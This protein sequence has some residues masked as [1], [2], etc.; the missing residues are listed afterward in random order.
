MSLPIGFV[1][2]PSGK[3]AAFR[4][5]DA[6]SVAQCHG[7]WTC[8]RCAPGKYAAIEAKH[9]A[10]V[11]VRRSLHVV[12]TCDCGSVQIP[13]GADSVWQDDIAHAEPLCL[14]MPVGAR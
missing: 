13:V 2:I 14:P 3:H 12:N 8:P 10:D 11:S 7:D 9:R 6:R 4:D 5:W 1:L